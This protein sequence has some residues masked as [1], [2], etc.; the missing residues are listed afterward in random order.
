M[1][2]SSTTRLVAAVVA[3]LA[4]VAVAVWAPLAARATGEEVRLRV[5][6]VDTYEPFADAYVE[7]AYPDLPR[8]P[9]ASAE[10]EAYWSDPARGAAYVPLTQ[11]GQVWVGGEVVRTPPASGRYLACDDSDWRLRCGIETVYLATSAPEAV[12]DA[13][14][15]GDAVATVKVDASGHAALIGVDVA[16]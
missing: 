2:T 5:Q 14:R 12:R 7:V 1:T 15:T 6:V 9:G 4:L 16:P 3:Q 13:L 8:Q 11:Q 10:D